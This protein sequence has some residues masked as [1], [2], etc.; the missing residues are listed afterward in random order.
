MI[1]DSLPF[2]S[3]GQLIGLSTG[4]NQILW[5]PLIEK[6][7][8]C[9]VIVVK[10]FIWLHT[11][12]ETYGRIW[13]SWVVSTSCLILWEHRPLFYARNSGV[14]LQYVASSH[15]FPFWSNSF[16]S[17]LTGWIPEHVLIRRYGHSGQRQNAPA[18]WLSAQFRKEGTWTRIFK[19]YTRGL[20]ITSIFVIHSLHAY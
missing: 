16:Q 12:Y 6:A 14:D 1:D 9:L 8:G 2:S 10:C 3:H 19:G 13:L 15:K 11:V 17:T 20:R 4:R 18:I 7:V 5:P